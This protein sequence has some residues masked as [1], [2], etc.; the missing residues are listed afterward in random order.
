MPLI[1]H[2]MTANTGIIVMIP[3]FREPDLLSTLRSLQRCRP[4]GIATEVLIVINQPEDCDPLT[5]EINLASYKET[6]QWITKNQQPGIKFMVTPPLNLPQKWAGVGMARKRGMDEA[7]WRFNQINH[8]GGIIVSLDADTF[9]DSNYLTEIEHHFQRNPNHVGATIEFSHQ[10]EGL[11]S[12]E[13]EGISLYEAYLRYYKMALKYIGYPNPIHTIGSAFTVTAKGYLQRGGMTRRKAG[14]DFY[15]LQHLTQLGTVGEITTTRVHP[16]ARVSDRVPFGTGPAMRQ[17]MDGT[18]DLNFT[19]NLQAFEDLKALFD[20]RIRCYRSDPSGW[21]KLLSELPETVT[22]YLESESM[23]SQLKELGENCSNEAIFSER[24][25]QLF[26]AFRILKFINFAH[27]N[28]YERRPINE[29]QQTL[30]KLM[31]IVT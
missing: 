14:E 27:G 6:S 10:T 26:N 1:Q 23:Y 3:A 17:W 2:E 21:Q 4:A 20:R 12:R 9:V 25:F 7:L 16:S 15:F 5:R 22:L 13:I 18:S 11:S 8:P 28:Y 30:N 19:Y 31:N 29:E 24:F